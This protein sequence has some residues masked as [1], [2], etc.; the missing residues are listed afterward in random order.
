[1]S[2]FEAYLQSL[3][4]KPFKKIFSKKNGWEYIELKN[5]EIDFFSS[6]VEGR[7]DNRWIKDEIE[8]IYGLHERDKPPTLCWPRP[9]EAKRGYIIFGGENE[10]NIIS[11]DDIMNRMLKQHTPKEIYKMI[12]K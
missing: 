2:E 9:E 10:H 6:M 11:G 4:Y 12:I 1:M 8:I 3:G 5:N 7:I